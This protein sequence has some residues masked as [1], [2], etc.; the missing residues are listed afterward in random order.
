MDWVKE[1]TRLLV[2]AIE[3][4]EN[5][6]DASFLLSG[7]DLA[8]TQEWLERSSGKEPFP[9]TLQHEYVR[10]SAEYQKGSR[11]RLFRFV[12]LASGLLLV[13]LLVAIYAWLATSYY[14]SLSDTSAVVVRAGHPGLKGLPGFDQAKIVTDH[15]LRDLADPSAVSDEDLTGFW[16][17]QFHGYTRW[18]E[19]LFSRLQDVE[20]GLAYWRLS[21][22]EQA[23]Q[24]LAQGVEAGDVTAV[25]TLV[26]VALQS[27]DQVGP[28]IDMLIKALQVNDDLHEV[29]LEALAVVRDTQPHGTAVQLE[30]LA[31]RLPMTSGF[32]AVAIA[33]AIGV[34]G[35][36]DLEINRQVVIELLAVLHASEKP[37]FSLAAARGL[38]YILVQHPEL[39]PLV[40]PDLT[41]LAFDTDPE[42]RQIFVAVLG[43][44]SDLNNSAKAMALQ[45]TSDALRDE[46]PM[47]RRAATD[48]LGSLLSREKVSNTSS[49][50]M[51]LEMV[52]DNE[53]IVRVAAVEAL[54]LLLPQT[55]EQDDIVA[56]LI[57]LVRK[58]ESVDVRLAGMEA[59]AS[60]Q[61]DESGPS[62]VAVLVEATGYPDALVRWGA[63]DAL[64]ILAVG[65]VAN[66]SQVEA[67]LQDS[68]SD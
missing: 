63:V 47:V 54:S 20:A 5:S 14:L 67:S 40:I 21:A 43:L 30:S 25:K 60:V 68:L 55:D 51:L 65:Q 13:G 59:L 57:S 22:A 28:A 18:G 19:Q 64:A 61:D 35:G 8:T 26:Y 15:S 38:Q 45:A 29:A 33:E 16:L 9:T 6:R 49:L 4:G 7:R 36:G 24:R 2:R 31:G 42:T 46:D 1:H 39:V 17:Q 52:E 58:D 34:L 3:W 53:G 56:A 50:P 10:A 37:D 27:E 66:V 48:T 32:E 41:E 44:P 12:S 11:R 62:I 23:L